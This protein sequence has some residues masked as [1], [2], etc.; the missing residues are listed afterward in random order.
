M[1]CTK[2]CLAGKDLFSCD[3]CHAPSRWNDMEGIHEAQTLSNESYFSPGL[4][5]DT[6]RQQQVG[7]LEYF[8]CIKGKNILSREMS[9]RKSSAKP[10]IAHEAGSGREKRWEGLI[11]Q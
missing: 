10:M 2:I 5:Y 6:P 7:L 3:P 1:I 11:L 4:F 8:L 9:F